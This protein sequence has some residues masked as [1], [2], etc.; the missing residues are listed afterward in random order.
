MRM[1]G[2]SRAIGAALLAAGLVACGGGSGDGQQG[3][4]DVEA[5]GSPDFPEGSKMAELAQAGQITVGIKYDQP[6]FG[7]QTIEGFEGFDVEIAK[8]IAAQLGIEPDNIEFTET[9]SDNREPFL[10]QQKVDMVVATYT[11]NE[12]RDELVDFAGPYY[13]AGQQIMVAS[14]NPQD[15]NGP[16]DL[17]GNTVCSARGSTPAQN[18]RQDYPEAAQ[19]MVLFDEYSKC[20]DALQNGQVDAVTTDNVILS[21]FVHE[22]G[23]EFELVGPTFSYEP[24]GVGVHQTEDKT[25]CKWLNDEAI[26]KLHE[27]GSWEEAYDSTIGQVAG[28][29]PEPPEVGSCEQ[30]GQPSPESS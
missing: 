29:P 21:G 6:L 20:R 10:Q 14:G 7:E 19:D 26:P 9:V 24:Y 2:T 28:E 5:E 18:I 15:I 1:R 4:P 13:V 30:P 22:S 27:D 12:E 23:G 11:I 8:Q 25:F 3:G 17:A 16:E